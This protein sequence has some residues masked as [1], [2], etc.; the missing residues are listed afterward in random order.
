MMAT[1]G[2]NPV[3]QRPPNH[4]N[5]MLADVAK[6]VPFK[7]AVHGE[8][9]DWTITLFKKGFLETQY[10]SDASRT[11]YIYNL[12]ARVVH[13]ESIMLQ[14]NT[15]YETMLSMIFTPSGKVSSMSGNTT[16][17]KTGGLKLG[18]RGFVS[19]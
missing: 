3:F 10:T 12:G 13:P 19:R 4:L 14:Q 8:D 18:P 9:L 5:P 2:D 15:S 17:E 7:N 11:H 1:T 16:K 6:M